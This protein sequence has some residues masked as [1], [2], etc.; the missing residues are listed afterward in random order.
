MTAKSPVKKWPPVEAPDLPEHISRKTIRK[1]NL[2]KYAT[3]TGQ[4]MALLAKIVQG[5]A[6]HTR[7]MTPHTHEGIGQGKVIKE[8][9]DADYEQERSELAKQ[10]KQ[11]T[12]LTMLAP[13]PTGD[14]RSVLKHKPN[15]TVGASVVTPI[16]PTPVT[17]AKASKPSS[18]SSSVVKTN[19]RDQ[20]IK[21]SDKEV[22]D[23]REREAKEKKEREEREAKE[24]K[25]KEE[26]EAKE[27]KEREEREAREKKEREERETKEK[28][29]GEDLEIKE[30]EEREK[31]K[32]DEHS[33]LERVEKEKK[34][35][36]EQ[37]NKQHDESKKEILNK[38]KKE[39]TKST[40]DVKDLT[41]S[42]VKIE[43][44]RT[45]ASAVKIELTPVKNEKPEKLLLR[46]LSQKALKLG[47]PSLIKATRDESVDMALRLE[48]T[49]EVVEVVTPQKKGQKITK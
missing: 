32:I 35:R 6:F 36:S 30:L 39:P 4:G 15:N 11:A 9:T 42:P 2:P 21:K 28:K 18:T 8:M 26:R 44:V 5:G 40:S 31:S 13:P 23:K 38:P 14:F 7:G 19:I 46:Q 10:P 34:G 17:V 24:K 37:E 20:D 43:V 3:K 27:K 49:E 29:E 45:E 41:L 22:Q 1:E 25:E 16:N 48:V 47:D 33:Q 12:V